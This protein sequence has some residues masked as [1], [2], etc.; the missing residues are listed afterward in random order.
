MYKVKYIS[1]SGNEFLFGADN[2]IVFDMDIGESVDVNIGVSQGFSQIGESVDTKSIG[3]RPINASG[4]VFKNVEQGKRKMRNTFPPFESGRLVFDD[5]HY[6]IAVHIKKPPSFSPVKGDGRFMMQFLAPFPYFSRVEKSSVPIGE[7][8]P[9]FSFPVNYAEP[10]KFGVK[11]SARYKSVVNDGDVP[12]PFE[13]QFTSTVESV[14][15]IIRD[16][17]NGG[18]LRLNMTVKQREVVTVYRDSNGVLRA[19]KN[20][21]GETVDVLG[22]VDENSTLFELNRGENIISYSDDAGGDNLSVVI[23]YSPAVV[24]IYEY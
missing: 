18:F 12:V 23:A 19:E 14:N 2:G 4:I 11:S 13:A 17:K 16:L 24:A 7:I 10:H 8:E 15:P 1:D 6:Y 21:G 20:V 9:A 5:G 3:S 22:A